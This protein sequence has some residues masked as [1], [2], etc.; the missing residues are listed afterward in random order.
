MA[1]PC[2]TTGCTNQARGAIKTWRPTRD[3]VTT[4]V[5]W[6]DRAVIVP[7]SADKMCGKHILATLAQIGSVLLDEDEEQ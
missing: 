7:K 2:S 3:N 4:Q 1:T 6:D 5:W